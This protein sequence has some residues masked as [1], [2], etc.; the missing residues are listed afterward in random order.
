MNYSMALLVALLSSAVFYGNATAQYRVIEN[1][2]HERVLLPPSAPDRSLMVVTDHTMVWDHEVALFITVTYDDPRTKREIDYMEV[3]DLGGNLVLI[4]WTDR[5]GVYQVA[6]DQVLLT[7]E[8]DVLDRRLVVV[9]AG[10]P[11]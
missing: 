7:E 8:S 4:T 11:A 9:T 3:Y 5:F 1:L 2:R 10:T 6:M